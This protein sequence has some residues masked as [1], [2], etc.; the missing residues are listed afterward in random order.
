MDKIYFTPHDHRYFSSKYNL[1]LMSNTHFRKLFVSTD[2]EHNRRKSAAQLYL[3]DKR[4][5]ELKDIWEARGRHILDPEFIDYLMSYMDKKTF[6]RLVEEVRAE[7]L[8]AGDRGTERGTEG[9]KTK[10]E[11]DI[12]TGFSVNPY[13]GLEY[14][15]QPHGRKEDGTNESTVECLADLEAG[16]YPE[17]LLW[18]YFPEPIYSQSLKKDICGI[19]GTADKVYIEPDRSMVGDYKFTKKPLSDYPIRYKNY[20]AEMLLEPFQDWA[21]LDLNGYKIQ[22]NTYGW[23]LDKHGLPPV[24][25]RIHNTVKDKEQEFIFDYEPDL[26]DSAFTKL[27][28]EGL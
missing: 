16:F 11:T 27:F 12:K 24:D 9:H 25:L 5:K 4:Y 20:G 21:S 14:P 26:I 22:L 19:A 3:K 17:L 6:L 15:V 13:N 18:W 1:E 7:W 28:I 23:M 8:S 2:W 10:E